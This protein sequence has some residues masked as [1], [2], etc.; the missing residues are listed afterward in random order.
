MCT[1][2]VASSPATLSTFLRTI[3][4]F[5]LVIAPQTRI[6][7]HRQSLLGYQSHSSRAS[8]PPSART[9]FHR[10]YSAAPD[11]STESREERHLVRKPQTA[12]SKEEGEEASLDSNPANTHGTNKSTFAKTTPALARPRSLVWNGS[13]GSNLWQSSRFRKHRLTA[14]SVQRPREVNARNS[15]HLRPQSESSI[16]GEPPS[17]A[18]RGAHLSQDAHLKTNESNS[19][20]AKPSIE[21]EVWQIQKT[22]LLKK[23]GDEGWK[24]RK[25][26]SPDA[27]DG[28]RALHAQYPDK[29]ST[30]VLAQEFKV[31]PE[32]IRRILRSKWRPSEEEMTSR[33]ER[34]A[35]RHDRIW[36]QKAEIGIRPLRGAKT[37]QP[38]QGDFLSDTILEGE[39]QAI[40][41]Q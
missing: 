30:P 40:S 6:E 22:A 9:T 38:V 23:F 12:L 32:V 20:K 7:S 28:I 21:R 4:G 1:G 13:K 5:D 17:S 18:P 36:D 27:L 37:H 33:R 15:R 25:R 29:Y 11:T 41:R 31:S 19:S 24:P 14:P 8:T 26:L 3:V 35:K 16:V 2:C 39:M 34:W 10:R